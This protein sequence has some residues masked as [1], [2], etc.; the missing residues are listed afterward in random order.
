MLL[1]NNITNQK[2]NLKKLRK[3]NIKKKGDKFY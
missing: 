3:Y 2:K 1:I